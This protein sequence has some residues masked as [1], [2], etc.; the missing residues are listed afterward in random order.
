MNIVKSY[1]LI[2]SKVLK[3]DK[4]KCTKCFVGTKRLVI[5][6]IDRSGDQSFNATSNNDLGNLITYCQ[7][8][9]MKKHWELS[10]RGLHQ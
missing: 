5:H 9:H 2:K 1:R 10:P 4:Y 7:S 8:C 3:R 6:H